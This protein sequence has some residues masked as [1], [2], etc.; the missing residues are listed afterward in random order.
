VRGSL[1]WPA[2]GVES[3]LRA[4]LILLAVAATGFAPSLACGAESVQP[5]DDSVLVFT[6]F[7]KNGEDGLRLAWSTNGTVWTALKNDQSFLRPNVGGGLMRDPN[8]IQGPDGTF[9]MVWTTAWNQQGAGYAHSQDLIH[10][11]E[12][13]LLDVMKAEPQA[14]NVWAPELFYDAASAQFV[15]YWST[16]IPG[17]FPETDQAGDSGYNHRIYCATTR[18]FG[19]FT[20]TRLLCEPG[21]NCIDATLVQDGARVLMFVKDETRNPPAKNLRLATSPSATGPFS[22]PSAPITGPYWAEGP[23]A[24]KLGDTWH[25][26]FDRYTQ[27]RYGVVTSKDLEHWTDESDQVKFPRDHRHGSVLKVSRKIWQGLRAEK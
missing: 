12:Q 11:S 7:R 5:G 25:V 2:A 17:R 19:T 8:I 10:W 27:G 22:K 20:P 15:L 14:R 4:W 16:T 3:A 23:T 1:P 18:D 21:F 9:H 6:S 26:Y 13:K 24:I